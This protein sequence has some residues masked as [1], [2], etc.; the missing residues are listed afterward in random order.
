M[1]EQKH[2]LSPTA[3]ETLMGLL[4]KAQ[5]YQA[6]WLDRYFPAVADRGNA[7]YADIES[8]T[9]TQAEAFRFRLMEEIEHAARKARNKPSF[10]KVEEEAVN[11]FA[12][13]IARFQE[14]LDGL[15]D[16]FGLTKPKVA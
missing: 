3:V 13:Q 8:M 2:E 10:N 15:C 16:V 1:A 11:G 7:E 6:K 12:Y 5:T 14:T 9:K 4:A